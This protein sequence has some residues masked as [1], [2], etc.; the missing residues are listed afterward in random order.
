MST[1]QPAIPPTAPAKRHNGKAKHQPRNVE[2]TEVFSNSGRDSVPLGP[3]LFPSGD[4]PISQTHEIILNAPGFVTN[5]ADI[6]VELTSSTEFIKQLSRQ[7]FTL[8]E[9][10]AFL[11][12]YSRALLAASIV[13]LTQ[14][15][16]QSHLLVHGVLGDVSSIININQA[17]PIVIRKYTLLFGEVANEHLHE[18]FIIRPEDHLDTV[19]RMINMAAVALVGANDAQLAT[20][21][22][23]PTHDNDHS[24]DPVLRL[25]YSNLIKTHPNANSITKINV[26]QFRNARDPLVD[27]L[28]AAQ[29]FNALDTAALAFFEGNRPNN[30]PGYANAG[31]WRLIHYAV[32][33]PLAGL[34]NGQ[35]AFEPLGDFKMK[36]GRVA[37]EYSKFQPL[38][39]DCFVVLGNEQTKGVSGSMMQLCSRDT[40]GNVIIVHQPC[41]MTPTEVAFAAIFPAPMFT[42]DHVIRARHNAATADA[43]LV[44][45]E[46]VARAFKN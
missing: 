30:A 46:F 44:R 36:V 20:Q 29:A 33:I 35:P 42:N 1:T 17:L 22:Y 37:A 19:R 14:N 32:G 28:N 5:I 38:T 41:P 15:L 3:G 43:G 16:C 10:D 27:A 11:V 45:R 6:I 34:G 12:D 25:G 18:K 40:I 21:Y 26:Q 9:R 7:A 4:P 13:A 8:A 23:S 31:F 24:I 2:K 39:E